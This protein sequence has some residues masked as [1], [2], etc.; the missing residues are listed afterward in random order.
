MKN[1]NPFNIYTSKVKRFNI[2]LPSFNYFHKASSEEMVDSKFIGRERNSKR[3]YS[4]LTE[5]KTKSG[6]YLV[7]G[8]RGMG[9][10][11]FVGRI[12]YELSIRSTSK[13]VLAGY[14]AFILIWTGGILLE[15][16]YIKSKLCEYLFLF[17]IPIIA[18]LFLI[19]MV[20][21]RYININRWRRLLF[22][23][24]VAKEMFLSEKGST[25]N[26]RMT[27]TEKIKAIYTLLHK[28]SGGSDDW[29]KINKEL[30]NTNIKKKSYKRICIS[31]NLG[32]E[33]LNEKDILSL[34]ARQL[35]IKY[36][37]YIH[38]PIANFKHWLLHTV[39]SF[40]L[41]TIII[42]LISGYFK[43]AHIEIVDSFFKEPNRYTTID[44]ITICLIA[45]VCFMLIYG[46]YI[47]T[48]SLLFYSQGNK[49]RK[50]KFLTERIE[51]QINMEKSISMNMQLKDEE[52]GRRAGVN[53][54]HK[55]NKKYPFAGT[56][57]IE[58]ELIEVL[59]LI[60]RNTW[61]PQFIFVFD[62]LDKVE[63]DHKQA[64]NNL[65]YTNEKNFP[66]GGTSRKRKQN[67]LHLLANMKLFISTAKAKFIFIAGR[68]LYDAYLAD[69]S[70]REFAISSIFNGV[71]Y[72]ESFCTNE[73]R[74]K[75][76]MSNAETYICK[77][78]IPKDFI[79]QACIKHFIKVKAEGKNFDRL[80]INLKLYYKYLI[81]SYL[82]FFHSYHKPTPDIP[83]DVRDCIDKAII[84]LYHFS[85]YLYHISNGSPKKMSLYFEKYIRSL[86]SNKKLTYYH[87]DKGK[88]MLDSHDI[89]IRI[90]HK[91][92]YCLSFGYIDQR[93]IGFIH[94]ISFPVTQIIIN[95]NQFGDKL[96]VS[97]SFLINHIYKFH[98]GGFSWR[99]MEQTPELLEVY[100]IPEFRSFINSILSY[101]AQSHIIPITCGLYQFK[102]R[103]QFSEEISL[104]SKFS[105]EIAALFNFTLD[106]SLSVKQHYLAILEDYNQKKEQE[107]QNN[108]HVIAGIHVIL[109]DLFMA[110]EEYTKAIFEYQT[111]IKIMAEDEKRSQS[112]IPMIHDQHAITRMLFLIRNM[113]KLGLAFEKRKTYESA[114]VTYNELIGRLIDFRYLDENSLGLN[115]AIKTEDKEHE[116]VLYSAGA[117]LEESS[118]RK[119][120]RPEI[121]NNISTQHLNTMYSVNGSDII[122]DFAHQMTREKNLII[123]RLSMLEDIRLIYQAILAKLFVLEKIE[124]GGITRANI[125]LLESEYTF[126]HLATNEKN[127][128]LISN[129]FFRRLGDIMFYKNGLTKEYYKDKDGQTS[130]KSFMEGLY[131][132][133]Y[134][135]RTEILDFCNENNCYHL[136]DKIIAAMYS[137]KNEEFENIESNKDDSKEKAIRK[138]LENA[139]TPYCTNNTPKDEELIHTFINKTVQYIQEIPLSKVLACNEHRDRMWKQ[140]KHLPCFACKYYN[141]SLRLLM[142]NLF[143]VN[144]EEQGKQKKCSKV[145]IILHEL[146]KGGSS[147]SLRQNFLIQLAEVL[148]CMGNVMVSCTANTQSGEKT[149]NHYKCKITREFLA[150]FLND[151]R[152]YNYNKKDSAANDLTGALE[153]IKTYYASDDQKDITM[154][155]KSL[156]YYWEAFICFRL[157]NDFKKA[158][159]S[160]KK[161]LRTIQKYVKLSDKEEEE[162]KEENRKIII[163]EYL[164]EIKEQILK[165]CLINIYAYYNYI[166][167][168]EIQKIKWIFY[169]QMYENISLNRLSMFPDI[170]EIMLVYYDILICCHIPEINSKDMRPSEIE[171]NKD[172]RVRLTGI[173]QNIAL[174]TLRQESTIYERILSLQFK[175]NMNQLILHHLFIEY[176]SKDIPNYYNSDFSQYIINFLQGYV[177]SADKLKDK[178][179]EYKYCF[180][181]VFDSSS[182]GIN[183][184]DDMYHLHIALSLLEFL[185]KDSMY[186][187]TRILEIITPYTS[188]TLFTNTFMGDIYQMLY[189]W[190]QVF[191]I[192]YMTYRASRLDLSCFPSYNPSI[193]WESGF[194]SRCP[195]S[196]K[197][198]PYFEGG[199][200]TSSLGKSKCPYYSVKCKYKLSQLEQIAIQLNKK[201]ELLNSLQTYQHNMNINL[202][203]MFF[204]E[205]LKEI[206]K[207]N[208]H[209]T[210]SNYSAEMAL[211]FYRQALDMHHE[212]KSY[213]D[214]INKMFYLDDDLK[215]DTIQFDLALE[216]LRINNGYI[217]EN[218]KQLLQVFHNASLYDVENFCADNETILS[219]QKRFIN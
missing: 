142:K 60:S 55:K 144:V 45:A 46:I 116:A 162:K 80:D 151:V 67:V 12:L 78:L 101:L 22:T 182:R 49:L 61:S 44:N 72:V 166:N 18:G 32:Q 13:T 75:D 84:L 76:I 132:W 208:I 113:L 87:W 138:L 50:L 213:K 161:I 174:G 121:N 51:A 180:Q 191:D 122:I 129:D 15:T 155:E 187:L 218:I 193:E 39:S 30:Y 183:E 164:N 94:Y 11:S 133:S 77:Q 74:E 89:D 177:K 97:A 159:G 198:C 105:E 179:K 152:T 95:A 202:P 150:P 103:K 148:D 99:N 108:P 211:K 135:I 96:L 139:V 114:Y 137:I 33:I 160:L 173:Y 147:K 5:E 7:T 62:E 102:F 90:K 81:K 65:E 216:R 73:R 68:E 79:V 194:Y 64:F 190:N 140:N 58:Q 136:K 214:T 93:T 38:S 195:A 115:Y 125:E 29:E 167:I 36:N 70:D 86:A 143:N 212:G 19:L 215:N 131:I 169:V 197:N 14:I 98:K 203:E 168:I 128:F 118:V 27:R 120:V 56:R 192:L 124:L 217:D 4:W 63:S 82:D 189:K 8:Y 28:K 196:D 156:M 112:N 83:K 199:N 6:S 16:A 100:R 48:R 106:E 20:Y 23:L 219:L 170:E 92:N 181:Y 205:I 175:A 204:S 201:R 25:A 110:D 59:E 210:L 119:K 111:A 209:Y 104:A 130:D 40:I 146:V 9:K 91:A 153:L 165:Q 69:L 172:L 126:L 207:S 24:K 57:E 35:Y 41:T 154:L 54:S 176:N 184:K 52:F 88:S 17:S 206:G 145:F 47:S 149:E 186:C 157:G 171:G 109:A 3:L 185:I 178:L 158:A 31:I 2:P 188:T 1:S 117:P 66:G 42:K 26:K 127:K 200:A 85:V 34:L 21:Y 163:R 43:N 107:G 10:S 71:I 53:M 134:N 141:K 123:Q 37:E